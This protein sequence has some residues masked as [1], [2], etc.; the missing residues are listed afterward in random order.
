M[1]SRGFVQNIFIDPDR[2]TWD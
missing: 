1:N 2:S